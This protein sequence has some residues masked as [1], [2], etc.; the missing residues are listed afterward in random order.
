MSG[1]T[2]GDLAQI[3]ELRRGLGHRHWGVGG[4][5]RDLGVALRRF[6]A[7]SS[8][9]VPH[10][11]AHQLRGEQ[12]ADRIDELARQ[13]ERTRDAMAAADRWLGTTAARWLFER[14]S[15]RQ[16]V[17]DGWDAA[18]ALSGRVDRVH[19]ATAALLREGGSR[20]WRNGADEVRALLRRGPAGSRALDRAAGGLA[21]ASAFARSPAIRAVTR[22]GGRAFAAAGIAVSAADVV[23]GYR[24]GDTEQLTTGALGVGAGAAML[25]VGCPPAMLAGAVV[26]GGLLVWEYREEIG[27]AGR[28]AGRAVVSGARAVADGARAVGDGARAVADGVGDMAGAAARFVDGLF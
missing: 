23:N 3:G 27:A 14:E 2:G 24:E 4:E 8:D 28:A 10:L 20:L 13:V 6:A 25:M 11:P 22:V 26:A 19:E 5:A 21:R 12:L 1:A 18:R 7:R 16:T 17:R 15:D 9:Y